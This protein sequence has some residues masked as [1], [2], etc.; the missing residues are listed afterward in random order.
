[1]NTAYLLLGGNMG[2]RVS[3]I[4]K[5]ISYIHASCGSVV[6]KSSLFESVP[7]GFDDKTQFINQVIKLETSMSAEDLLQNLL[8]IELLLGRVRNQTKN[9]HSRNIDI[10]I[11]FFND[12]IINKQAL[13]IPHP[14]LQERKFTLMPLSEIASDLRHPLFNKTVNEL[15]NECNDPLE[16]VKLDE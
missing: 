11:L 2:D 14:L 16:V 8:N 10:D 1:M 4:G 12:E 6:K 9:Y 13:K 15:L 3:I 5:A 7:W